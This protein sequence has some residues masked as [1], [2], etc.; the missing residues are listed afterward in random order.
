MDLYNLPPEIISDISQYLSLDQLLNICQTSKYG[1]Q[2]CRDDY[3]WKSLL[4]TRYNITS[5]P[6]TLSWYEYFIEV[7]NSAQLTTTQFEILRKVNELF[8]KEIQ[9][10]KFLKNYDSYSLTQTIGRRRTQTPL[11]SVVITYNVN[12]YRSEDTYAFVGVIDVDRL[13]KSP[14]LIDSG[15]N[16][17]SSGYRGYTLTPEQLHILKDTGVLTQKDP[18]QIQYTVELTRLQL[19]ELEYINLNTEG[20]V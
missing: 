18:E 8:P 15:G 1:Y 12:D 7:Y 19:F 3:L 17:L 14:L 9:F 11:T 5:K 4:N 20:D 13:S 10:L 6:K 2:V 16:L